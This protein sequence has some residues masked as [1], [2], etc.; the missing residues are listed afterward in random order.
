[1]PKA[2][3]TQASVNRAIDAAESRGWVVS[4]YEV[5][6]DG[7]IRIIRKLDKDT[8]QPDPMPK[9]FAG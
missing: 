2:T 7:T 8:E 1:M 9:K 5:T 3:F 4:G 6:S